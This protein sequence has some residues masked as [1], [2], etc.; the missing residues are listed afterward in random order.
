VETQTSPAIQV[1]VQSF[2]AAVTEATSD[3]ST[4]ISDLSAQVSQQSTIAYVGIAAG[5]IAIIIALVL[6]RQ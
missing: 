6:R 5:V 1:S 3:L 2:E 4:Q